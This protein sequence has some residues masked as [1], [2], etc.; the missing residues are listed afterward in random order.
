MPWR[1][2]KGALFWE[3][4]VVLFWDAPHKEVLRGVSKKKPSMFMV[5][6]VYSEEMHFYG[7]LECTSVNRSK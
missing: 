6:G 3:L 7:K 5:G 2:A 1:S 4:E